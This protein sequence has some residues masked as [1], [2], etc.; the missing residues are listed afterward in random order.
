MLG[1]NYIT[2]F[3]CIFFR[4]FQIRSIRIVLGKKQQ[5]PDWLFCWKTNSNRKGIEKKKKTEANKIRSWECCGKQIGGKVTSTLS[6]V[7]HILMQ[8]KTG[9]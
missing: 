1:I 3:E 5:T 6:H 2:E 4:I 7:A 8:K 9:F